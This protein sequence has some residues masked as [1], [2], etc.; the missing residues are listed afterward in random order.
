M[1]TTFYGFLA[2]GL[3]LS[4]CGQHGG[5]PAG[6]GGFSIPVA[7]APIARGTISQTFSVTGSVT[8]KLSAS[9]SSV[10]SGTVMTVGAQIGQRVQQGESLIQIDDSTLR[11]QLQSAQAALESSQ[12]RL[13]QAQATSTGDLASSDAALA[14]AR[15]ANQTAQLTLHRDQ[16]LLKKGYVA[17]SAVDQAWADAMSS[18]AQ[19]RSAEV[20]ARNAGLNPDSRSAALANLRSAQAAVDQAR[21]QVGLISAQ[22]AQTDVRAPFNGVV[23][24]RNVDP[25]SLAAPGTTLMEVAQLDPVF[26][27]V[28]IAGENL[29][30]VSVGKPVSVTVSG[31]PGRAWT[32]KIEYLALA[33]VPGTL[34]FKARI[35]IANPDFALRGGMV[36]SIAIEQARKNGV[37]LAPRASVFQTDT[38]YA[39]YIIDAGKAKS[40]PV[41]VGLENDQEME[42][43]GAGLTAGTQAILNHAA[44]LQPGM[45]VQ[46]LP[47]Q[48]QQQHA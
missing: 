15:A 23:V 32:G 21:A 30:Y 13:A 28:D 12:A 16:E 25:G 19:L 46:P 8:P 35:P 44:T 2:A 38:G 3:V 24:T 40:I 6:M 14:S 45:P 33:A 4:G 5:P 36:A 7:A 48:K 20:A 37:L 42:V 34:T 22:L 31:N 39:M 29:K 11:A 41:T 18:Q 27:D 1:K 26:V 17:Q 9:L 43:S 10:A 47:S